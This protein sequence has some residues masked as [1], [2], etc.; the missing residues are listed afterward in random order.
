MIKA[1]FR[2]LA[3]AIAGLGALASAA[4]TPRPR[5]A[6]GAALVSSAVA[7]PATVVG[8]IEDVRELDRHGRAATLALEQSLSGP[9]E[10]GTSVSI[11]WEE[12]SASRA[13]RF[14]SEDRI[15]VS[16]EA[17]PGHSIW[18]TRLPDPE[19]RAQA[20]HVSQRGDAFLR[21][22]TPGTLDTLRHYVL[23]DIAQREGATGTGYLVR[24]AA[25]AEK[26]VALDAITVLG[27]RPQLA[28]HVDASLAEQLVEAMVRPDV[29]ARF[30]SAVVALIAER[31]LETTRPALE[32][33][34][35]AL[36]HAAPE[37]F[38]ALARLDGGLTTDQS[39]RLIES[40]PPAQRR[41]AVRHLQGPDAVPKLERLLRR[42]SAPAVRA[43]AGE[44]L[45]ELEGDG[46][47]EPLL[48][49]LSDP[50]PQVRGTAA[51]LL[52]DLGEPA[53]SPLRQ[54]V[55][56]NDPEAASAAVVALGL[57]RAGDA[58]AVLE[59]IA[60]DHP[61]ERVRK[62]AELTLSGTLGHDH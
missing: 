4:D 12:L 24:L 52:A 47:L 18:R 43:A 6:G 32:R 13:A 44:R 33:R 46:A 48:G 50:E 61:E 59:E 27:D 21:D 55:R 40:A 15:L 62:L 39:A 41:V 35:D 28:R 37:V 11:V 53:V 30:R 60:A 45:F 17:L 34:A 36:P 20:W 22:P 51:R 2:I 16:L 38:E 29:D 49:A 3:L 9:I 26:P 54:I 19:I 25:H 10:T 7:A 31:Q 42:D 58:R 14:G 5:A 57:S 1:S 8:T 23:L 56:G